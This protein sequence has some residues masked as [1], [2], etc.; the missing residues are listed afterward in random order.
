MKTSLNWLNRYLGKPAS[1]DDVCRLLPDVG[2]PIETDQS[3]P[4]TTFGGASDIAFETEITSNRSDCLSHVGLAREV[5]AASGNNLK[6]PDC[7]LPSAGSEKV[8]SLT[9]VTCED[10]ALCPLYIA[11]VI[12]NVK[13]GPSPQWMIDVLEAVG[14]RTV[15]NVVDITN[16]VLLELGQPLHAFDM[17]RLRGGR[18]IVRRAKAGEQF[19]AIDGT[20]HTLADHMLVIA[21]SEVPVA[22]AG[23][24]GGKDSEVGQ[25]TTDILLESAMFDPLS[26]RRTGRALKLKSDS[27]YR[28][29]RGVDPLG[30][31]TASKRAAK[32]ICELAGGTLAQ[33]VIRVGIAPPTPRAIT[34]RIA[35]CN[36]LLGTDLSADV[37]LGLLDRLGLFPK[38]DGHGI[39][40]CIVPTFRLDLERE[41]DLIEEIARSYGL[42]HIA[43]H[44]KIELVV[45][46]VQPVRV[47]QRKLREALVS[48]GFHETMTFSFVGEKQ[49]QPFLPA[50]CEPVIVDHDRCRSEP[51][52]RPSLL[53]SLLACRKRNQDVGNAN[54]KVF[55]L[56]TT[57]RREGGEIRERT[58]LAL[59]AD[60]TD[61]GSRDAAASMALRA[62]R[63]AIE[64]M[65]EAVGGS[66]SAVSITPAE[67]S[68]HSHA[69]S[70]AVG[71]KAIG[72]LGVLCDHLVSLFDLQSHV[73]VAELDL[74]SLLSLYPPAQKASALAKYP[75]IERD[76]SFV[77]GDEV[78]WADIEAN[79]QATKPAM[80]ESLAFVGSYR[81]KPIPAGRKSV[82]LRMIFREPLRTLRHEEVDPQVA[83]VV[84]RVKASLGAELRT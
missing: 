33:G 26:V 2:L 82:T 50:G 70:V 42:N 66:G 51:M 4:V 83:Q 22:V 84:E 78:R 14:L 61:T 28:F 41:V 57:W 10:P 43:K 45:R 59:V 35:R 6:L 76:L 74:V 53:P 1:Y 37:M 58:T 20:K 69:G 68:L 25:E 7:V 60:I 47:A 11:R 81:G 12:R 72:T 56:A 9:K 46:P 8:E 79:V 55:E 23:V 36:A 30:V 44:D 27:S 34:M 19:I 40:T 17:K 5:A 13:V 62:L 39:I 67:S 16:F 29:E 31:E 71:G 38:H 65:I 64:E 52:L 54:V 32:L 77:V 21:D 15:N 80:L 24:M 49:G 73:V 18:I 3:G 63:G 75:A 48:H